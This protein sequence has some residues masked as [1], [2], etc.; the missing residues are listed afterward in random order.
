M[1]LTSDS[2]YRLRGR[3]ILGVNPPVTDFAWFDLWA[4]PLGLLN[5]LGFLRDQGNRVTLL[6]CLHEARTS[7]ISHGRWKVRRAELPKPEA[8]RGIPRRYYRFGLGPDELRE[9][10]GRMPRPDL[11]LV[12]SIM[13]YWYPGVFECIALLKDVFPDVPL[14]LGGIYAALCP[15]HAA[16]GGADLIL[17]GAA[18]R[19]P[20]FIPLDLYEPSADDP[21]GSPS[22]MAGGAGYAVLATS[23]GCPGRCSYCASSKLNPGFQPR[24]ADEVKNDADRQLASGLIQDLAFYDDALLLDRKLFRQICEHLRKY[25]ALRLHSPN[26]L[27]V[28]ALDES[29][30]ELLFNSGFSTLRLSLEGIDPRTRSMSEGKAGRENH[31]RAVANLLKAGFRPESIETYLLL[32]L[33]GQGSSDVE[34][35]IDYVKSVGSKPKLGEFSPIPGTPLFERE[36]REHP[37]IAAE[38]LWHNNSIY[39]PYLSRRAPPEELQRLKGLSRNDANF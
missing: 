30:C 24:P 10:L 17:T 35:A 20:A 33:P 8:L 2:I 22:S 12:T 36:A 5:L 39:T 15:D 7:P 38:P 1:G 16:G 32:G 27:S 37:I 29:C 34:A 28:A 6:D 9:R 4:K 25:P 3:R 23:Y 13:T 18:P 31:Q 21:T 11:I 19:R 14:A 26:G